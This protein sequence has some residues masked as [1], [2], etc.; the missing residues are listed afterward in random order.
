MKKI[1]ISVFISLFCLNSFAQTLSK[2]DSDINRIEEAI[3]N[4][5]YSTASKIILQYPNC[6]T[7]NAFIDPSVYLADLA[8]N[9]C[10]NINKLNTKGAS[11]NNLTFKLRSLKDDP[12][13]FK[14]LEDLVVLL[15]NYKIEI[16]EGDYFIKDDI[17]LD[18]FARLLYSSDNIHSKRKSKKILI[19]L[20]DYDSA[21]IFSALIKNNYFTL[22]DGVE[23]RIIYTTSTFY[24]PKKKKDE[25]YSK[26]RFHTINEII[27]TYN[28]GIENCPYTPKIKAFYNSE[29]KKAEEERKRNSFFV[30]ID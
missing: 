26:S 20:L 7:K 5:D 9:E 15:L 3:N 17:Y 6:G 2:Q 8:N 10:L 23:E 21:N 11:I 4:N 24:F 28:D 30:F 25:I 19:N 12:I 29:I 13:K 14:E 18:Y 1:I 16:N 22:Y 27:Y